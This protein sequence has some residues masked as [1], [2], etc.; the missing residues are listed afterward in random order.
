VNI[1]TEDTFRPSDIHGYSRGDG[2]VFSKD[3]GKWIQIC[4]GVFDIE[5][6]QIRL[7]LL[8]QKILKQIF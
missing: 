2:V 6:T 8:N 5:V 4:H 7:I 3:R 1:G